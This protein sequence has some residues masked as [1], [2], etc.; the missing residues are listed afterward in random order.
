MI[1][2]KGL[3][4]SWRFLWEYFNVNQSFLNVIVLRWVS[5]FLYLTRNLGFDG[6]YFLFYIERV[7]FLLV[8][9][10]T[11]F[12]VRVDFLCRNGRLVPLKK[13]WTIF[14]NTALVTRYSWLTCSLI[15]LLF[16][17]VYKELKINGQGIYWKFYVFY[18][19]R[20]KREKER[21]KFV[22]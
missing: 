2:I 7:N 19:C 18:C 3:R 6:C 21:D 9:W 8:V 10:N 13:D 12:R 16:L 5:L 17:N 1:F 22:L 20:F 14:A 4:T 15:L 11:E